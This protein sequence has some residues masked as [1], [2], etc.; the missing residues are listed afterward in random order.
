MEGGADKWIGLDDILLSMGYVGMGRRSIQNGW[1]MMSRWTMLRQG[2][3]IAYIEADARSGRDR[4]I[5]ECTMLEF[6]AMFWQ[7]SRWCKDW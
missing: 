2:G 7:E 6:N 1:I 3:E 5:R 4:D